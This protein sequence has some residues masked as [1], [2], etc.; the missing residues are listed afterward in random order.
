MSTA[1]P[2]APAATG[3]GGGI[4]TFLAIA[5][6]IGAVWLA[7]R[8]RP[9]ATP[10]AQPQGNG[11]PPDPQLGPQAQAIQQASQTTQA[12]VDFYK[13]NSKPIAEIITGITDWI[14]S[15]ER[16]PY[17]NDSAPRETGSTINPSTG[18]PFT[19]APLPDRFYET[20]SKPIVTITRTA[21]ATASR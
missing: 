10:G 21:A 14:R 17:S 15:F 1:A 7:T 18:Q 12:A 6:V 11:V 2:A 13:T 19:A 3:E 4:G 8:P 20:E 5:L 9:S 16:S